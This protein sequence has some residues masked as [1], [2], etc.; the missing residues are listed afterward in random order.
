MTHYVE[1]E[2]I[3]YAKHELN[4]EEMIKIEEHLDKC[5]ECLMTYD[6]L[7][8]NLNMKSYIEYRK[9]KAKPEHLPCLT[10]KELKLYAANKTTEEQE[11]RITEHLLICDKCT[12]T[13]LTFS[14]LYSLWQSIEETVSGSLNWIKDITFIPIMEPSMGIPRSTDTQKPD[15]IITYTEDEIKIQIPANKDCYL[16]IIRWDG[17]KLS[18]LFPDKNSLDTF[19]KA[20]EIK[21]LETVIEGPAGIHQIKV[22]LTEEKLL[23]CEDIDFTNSDSIRKSLEEFIEKLEEIEKNKWSQEMITYE[24]R[25]LYS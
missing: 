10:H 19:I 12:K 4:K 9:Y 17:E 24:V 18:L 1:T 21:E 25:E 13:Y 15:R 14:E 2:L 23:P 3:K 11:K 6:L 22:F 7:W 16:T 20:N 8:M 5:P